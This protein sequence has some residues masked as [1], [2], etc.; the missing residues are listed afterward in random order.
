MSFKALSDLPT[1]LVVGPAPGRILGHQGAQQLPLS[2][3]DPD[4]DVPQLRFPALTEGVLFQ[5]MQVPAVQV[6]EP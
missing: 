4:H 1:L 2:G 5:N 6:A 3:D